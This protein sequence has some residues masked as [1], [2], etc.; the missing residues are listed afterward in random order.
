MSWNNFLFNIFK[1]SQ[2]QIPIMKFFFNLMSSY[3]SMQSNLIS[4]REYD[5]SVDSSVCR[6]SL[7]SVCQVS[8]LMDHH[9][10]SQN[11]PDDLHIQMLAPWTLS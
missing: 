3:I 1:L 2:N 10:K 8:I 4:W 11:E 9:N 6:F 7:D 5:L